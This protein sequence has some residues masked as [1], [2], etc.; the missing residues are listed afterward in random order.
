MSGAARVPS[1]QAAFGV[2]RSFTG[3]RWHLAEVNDS[4]VQALARDANISPTLARL[5]LARGV[6]AA[7][8]SDYLNPTLRR[9]LPEPLTLKDM[10]KAIARVARAVEQG[11]RVAVWGD[12]DVDGSTSAAL[13]HEFFSALGMPPRVYIPDRLTEG[14]GPNTAGLLT[15]KEEGTGLVITVD[16]GAGSAGPLA[17]ARHAGLDVVVLDHH[18]VET[19]PP[20]VAHVNPNQPGDESGLGFVCA[21]GITFLFAVA[22]NRALRQA[23]FYERK[24]LKEPA[25][26]A[27][28][29]FVGLATVC[30][31]VPLRGVNRAFVRTGLLNMNRLDRPGLS[32]LSKVVKIAPPFTPYHLGFLFGPRINAGG[33]IGRSSLGVELLTSAAPAAEELALNLDVHNRERQ[34]LEKQILDEAVAMTASQ[35]NAPFIFAAQDGWHPGV[36]GI[37]AGRLKDRYGKPAFVAGFEGGYGRGSARSIP[38]IDI[39][40]MIRAA[41]DAKLIESGGGH[42]MAGGFGLSPAQVDG[43]YRF[44]EA[45]FAQ[46]GEALAAMA[47]LELD[48]IVSP[49]GATV[50]LIDEIEKAG[51]YGAGNSEPLIVVPDVLVV[52]ADPVGDN[53][54]RLRLQGGDGAR[55]DAIAF[56]VA[57]MALGKALLES[58]GKRIHVAGRLR[59]DEWQGQRRVQL[60]LEDAAPAGA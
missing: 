5:L 15:L 3:R 54:V 43:F 20:A 53:H 51:P 30:D 7:D 34:A 29:D 39:G 35:A 14:Y 13:L 24:G 55:L 31:V 57:D 59:A 50:A 12:Y 41:R 36:V 21:A 17:D 22:L 8:V 1:P 38:G 60:Q 16:C 44:L 52:F 40:A 49:A 28:A 23:G 45:Q 25:L 32:A 33:R 10:D 47:E 4:A 19:P 9:F 11:E 46:S 26:L 48:S 27:Y 18:A 6:E 56:R 42:A 2:A 37:V 58:R